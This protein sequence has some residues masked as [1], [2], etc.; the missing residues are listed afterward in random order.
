MIPF[1]QKTPIQS[2]FQKH[3]HSEN[4]HLKIAK[5]ILIL[6]ILLIT[7]LGGLGGAVCQSICKSALWGGCGFCLCN[8]GK[9]CGGVFGQNG[10]GEVEQQMKPIITTYP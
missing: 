2:I 8:R 9:S 10:S 3:K 4:F 7:F 5:D 6:T 1:L